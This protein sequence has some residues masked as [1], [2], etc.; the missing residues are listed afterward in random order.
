VKKQNTCW[1]EQSDNFHVFHLR[2]KN[3]DKLGERAREWIKKGQNSETEKCIGREKTG[4]K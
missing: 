2:Q 3:R 4:Q 1:A